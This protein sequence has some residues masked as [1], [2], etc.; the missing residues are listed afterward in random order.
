M[1]YLIITIIFILSFSANARNVKAIL[2]TDNTVIQNNEILKIHFRTSKNI[3]YVE[4]NE[5]SRIESNDSKKV[6]G[7]DQKSFKVERIGENTGF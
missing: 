3:D 2:L 6:E 7:I 1:K 4:L 5:G